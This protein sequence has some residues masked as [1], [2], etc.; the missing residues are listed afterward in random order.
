MY[1]VRLQNKALPTLMPMEHMYA[2]C[3]KGEG[4]ADERDR[5]Y[6][7]TMENQGETTENQ[8][9]KCADAGLGCPRYGLDCAAKYQ[10]GKRIVTS[11]AFSSIGACVD[12]CVTLLRSS[13]T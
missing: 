13:P 1:F 8:D 4:A 3:D 12:C 2:A 7:E 11:S 6:A 5:S 9:L 10:A